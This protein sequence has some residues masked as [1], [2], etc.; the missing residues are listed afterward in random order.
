M[1]G[2]ISA[3]K[4]GMIKRFIRDTS[5]EDLKEAV[6]EMLVWLDLG[7]LRDGKFSNMANNIDTMLDCGDY[8][9]YRLAEDYILMEAARRYIK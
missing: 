5:D 8:M 3:L 9:K 7:D 4:T 2:Q 6:H 1:T